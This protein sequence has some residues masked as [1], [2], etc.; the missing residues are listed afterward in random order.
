MQVIRLMEKKPG[1]A[2]TI[3]KLY[4][5][6]EDDYG[7]PLSDLPLMLEMKKVDSMMRGSANE[8]RHY[9]ALE[10]MVKGQEGCEVIKGDSVDADI[11][12]GRPGCEVVSA[13]KDGKL[14]VEDKLAAD[15]PFKA[16]D[17]YARVPMKVMRSRTAGKK[18]CQKRSAK[19]GVAWQIHRKHSDSYRLSDF[20]V[21]FTSIEENIFVAEPGTKEWDKEEEFLNGFGL[22]HRIARKMREFVFWAYAKD[23]ISTETNP[24]C[25]R[26]KCDKNCGFIY[27]HPIATI[28]MGS[29]K[30]LHPWH[31]LTPSCYP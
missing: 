20:D 2:A 6:C 27:N 24:V 22:T 9:H 21:V 16:K 29:R 30:V 26:R 4:D 23:L 18:V 15:R 10:G 19:T 12:F 11:F 31:L 14:K 17:G 3:L 28:E 1:L 5:K 25:R 7:I 13:T 8:F